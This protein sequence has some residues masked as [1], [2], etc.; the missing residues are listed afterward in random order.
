VA[1]NHTKILDNLVIDRL[2][3]I[4]TDYRLGK[5]TLFE[6][7]YKFFAVV[8]R[9]IQPCSIF[10]DC[11]VVRIT[12]VHNDWR[13]R[14]SGRHAYIVG[15]LTTGP[16]DVIAPVGVTSRQNFGSWI[17]EL[18]LQRFELKNVSKYSLIVSGMWYTENGTRV[19]F[20]WKYHTSGFLGLVSQGLE[21]VSQ[22]LELE[23]NITMSFPSHRNIPVQW[24]AL[25]TFTWTLTYVLVRSISVISGL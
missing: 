8:K 14:I 16:S 6:H 1:K 25:A 15:R 18:N 22:G 3:I 19:F 12:R 20:E 9:A 23:K 2:N 17:S 4:E 5:T 10:P 11:T 7:F 24:K 13:H 21:I